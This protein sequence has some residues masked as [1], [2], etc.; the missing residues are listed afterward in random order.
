MPLLALGGELSLGDV[1]M[2]L[3]EA[4]AEDVQGGVIPQCGHWVAEERPGYLVER[5]LAFFE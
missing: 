5:L 3:Y 1:T 2:K 4:V